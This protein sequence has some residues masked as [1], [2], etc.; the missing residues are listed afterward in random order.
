MLQITLYYHLHRW[1]YRKFNSLFWIFAIFLSETVFF[2][3]TYVNLQVLLVKNYLSGEFH[4][5]RWF[6]FS[7]HTN[8]DSVFIVVFTVIAENS[9]P[10]MWDI[11]WVKWQKHFG[12]FVEEMAKAFRTFTALVWH[13][14]CWHCMQGNGS[15]WP[16]TKPGG[17]TS[18][19]FQWE[20]SAHEEWKW[21]QLD[22]RFCNNEGQKRSKIN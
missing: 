11:L 16:M 17:G 22:L 15:T 5:L 4:F 10:C 6:L 20:C 8:G 1:I 19:N 14:Y 9:G 2:V 7:N 12:Y 21:S 3:D 13:K 18:P